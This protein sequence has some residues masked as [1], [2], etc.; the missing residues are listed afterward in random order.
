MLTHAIVVYRSGY[1][2]R[3]EVHSIRQRM[4]TVK[5]TVCIT[6]IDSCQYI[7][8]LTDPVMLMLICREGKDPGEVHTH[9]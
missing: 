7:V 2:S 4:A 5:V 8:T 1:R 6:S 9:N 3:I